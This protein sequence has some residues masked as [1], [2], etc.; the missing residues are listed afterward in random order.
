MKGLDRPQLHDQ[1]GDSAEGRKGQSSRL[2]Q[3]TPPTLPKEWLHVIVH[4]RPTPGAAKPSAIS[5]CG[6]QSHNLMFHFCSSPYFLTLQEEKPTHFGVFLYSPCQRD[7]G[8]GTSRWWK[9][10]ASL[11]CSTVFFIPKVTDWS[12]LPM[13]QR[14]RNPL[15][16]NHESELLTTTWT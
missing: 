11:F 1:R 9:M 2:T 16:W 7:E 15:Q 10:S 14:H 13:H 8:E 3:V 6:Y 12:S 4:S 5:C